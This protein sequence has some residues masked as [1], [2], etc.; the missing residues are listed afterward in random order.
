MLAKGKLPYRPNALGWFLTYPKCEVTPPALLEYLR[1]H[2]TILEY[3]IA[4]E[5][6]A[7]GSF[8]LHAFVKLDIRVNFKKGLF[9]IPGF[10]GNY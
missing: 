7:D 2:H 9:D 3:V 6:H 4:R 10:H 1:E 8:H 5:E